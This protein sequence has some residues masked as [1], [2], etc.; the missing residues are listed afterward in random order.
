MPSTT[1]TYRF[2]LR[3]TTHTLLPRCVGSDL[4]LLLCPAAFPTAHV[5]AFEIFGNRGSAFGAVGCRV[6]FGLFQHDAE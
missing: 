5:E 2:A 1:R 6:R 4:A 3:D